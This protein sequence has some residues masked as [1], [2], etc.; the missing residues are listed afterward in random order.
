MKLLNKAYRYYLLLLLMLFPVMITVHYFLIRHQINREV[1]SL[2]ENEAQRIRLALREQGAL[3]ASRYIFRVDTLPGEETLPERTVDTLIEEGYAERPVSYRRYVFSGQ[4][5]AAR[6][7]IELRLFRAEMN[8]LNGSLIGSTALLIL[9]IGIGL[10]LI[11]WKITQQLRKPFFENL[12]KLRHYEVTQKSPVRLVENSGIKEFDAFS[13]VVSGLID[14]V[15]RDFQ[16]LKEFNENIS[17]EIQTPLAI[18]RNKMVLLLESQNLNEKEQKWVAAAYQEA[19]KLS[20]IGKS[21]TL[22][23]RI[24]N[25]EFTRLSPVNFRT[26]IENILHNMEEIINFKD[27]TLSTSLNPV[28]AKCD[29]I[30]ANVLFTN[31]IKNAVQH[32]FSGGFIDIKLENQS[33]IMQNSGKIPDV[34]TAQLFKRFQRDNQASN[35]LGLGL[36]ISQ[37]ICEVYGFE[38]DYRQ[39]DGIHTFTLIFQAE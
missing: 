13:G 32:N 37:K 16:N 30:L 5:D 6:L 39:Q 12:S 19:N 20:R 33:F 34:E 25:Q 17:H 1:N 15:K 3:P 21:L 26:L 8:L 11:N 38:L 31:L 9:L 4:A 29:P 10:F 24:E 35:S 27:L 14:Q 22:I 23:S 36:A 2:L 18:I 28:V 7:R